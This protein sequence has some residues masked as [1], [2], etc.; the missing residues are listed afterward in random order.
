MKPSRPLRVVHIEDSPH[1]RE[2]VQALLADVPGLEIVG[3]AD[4]ETSALDLVTHLRPDVVLVDLILV[5]GNGL[6]LVQRI[7]QTGSCPHI[8]IFTN[9]CLLQTRNR[10]RALGVRDYF[11][12]TNEFEALKQALGDLAV[13]H[14]E[15]SPEL[16]ATTL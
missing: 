8:M 1:I 6:R 12:K 4:S 5:G 16:S 11:D 2:S 15:T 3:W 13:S 14:F 7:L 10:A 9:Y